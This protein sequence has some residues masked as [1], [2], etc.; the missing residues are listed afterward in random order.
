M[1][2]RT[3]DRAAVAGE[4]PNGPHEESRG[5]RGV[6]TVLAQDQDRFAREPAYLSYLRDAFGQHGCKLRALN[7]RGDDSPE[8]QLTDGYSTR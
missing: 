2:C 7:H 1:R 8:G 6:S 3:L 4:V 5:R